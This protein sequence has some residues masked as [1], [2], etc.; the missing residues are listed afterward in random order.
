MSKF[1]G[2]DYMLLV[3][4]FGEPAHSKDIITRSALHYANQ[5]GIPLQARFSTRKRETAE[6]SSF[7]P[8]SFQYSGQFTWLTESALLPLTIRLTR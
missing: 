6:R 7:D 1:G 8:R 2:S 5:K 3:H 4:E